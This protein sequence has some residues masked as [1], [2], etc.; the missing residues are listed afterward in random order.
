MKVNN[1]YL[2]NYDIYKTLYIKNKVTIV[3]CSGC[4]FIYV[5]E[6]LDAS[7]IEKYYNNF[8]YKSIIT[9]ERAIRRDAKRSCSVLDKFIGNSSSLFDVGCG[10]G[11]FLDEAKKKGWKVAGMD[12][13]A[14]MVS[15]AREKLHLKV[16]R[17]DAISYKSHDKYN[18]VTLHQ[19]IEH[20]DDP[21]NLL[22][23]CHKLLNKGGYIYIATPNINSISSQVQKE[24]FDHLI[25][26]EHLSYFSLKTL[27]SALEVAGFV[28]TYSGSWS[29]PPDL[30]G[31]I[32]SL[33]G[34]SHPRNG[35]SVMSDFSILNSKESQVSYIKKIKS[36]LFDNLFCQFFYPI[37]NYDSWGTNL[38]VIAQKP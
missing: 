4:E 35:E 30:G 29:Y 17:G 36:F 5:L 6:K 13:S 10:R 16:E 8:D 3:Q 9:A 12:S 24:H 15:Y 34:T 2:C 11:F 26:P 27:K 1:C 33:I 7:T 19:V 38:E 31:I 21:I 32:K 25:P 22:K 18:L 28:V 14:S 37:L 20:F 23:N